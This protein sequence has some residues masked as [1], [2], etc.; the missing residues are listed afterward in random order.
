MS[1]A[2][3]YSLADSTHARQESAQWA[4]FAAPGSTAE[5]CN[6]W[7]ALLCAQVDRAQGGLVL[8]GPGADGSYSP[9]AT[10][11]DASHN[12][13]H[14]G[15][16]AQAALQQRRGVVQEG[17]VPATAAAAL[18][19]GYP[20]EVEGSLHG[21][22]ILKIKPQPKP[23]VQRVLRQLLR[24]RPTEELLLHRQQQALAGHADIGIQRLFVQAV[25]EQIKSHADA[26]PVSILP[27]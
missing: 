10:W 11:P 9:V 8:L 16:T 26:H 2:S 14:L 3:I 17:T 24:E 21:T 27:E 20:I 13:V 12:L 4:R 15:P 5:F 23:E 1:G 22:I 25:T 18:L 19:I 6:S 7:L